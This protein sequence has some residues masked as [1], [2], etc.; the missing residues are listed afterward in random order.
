[1]NQKDPKRY[2]KLKSQIQPYQLKVQ[3]ENEVLKMNSLRNPASESN[4]KH[5]FQELLKNQV[6][7]NTKMRRELSSKVDELYNIKMEMEDMRCKVKNSED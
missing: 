4:E 1:M 6:E 3:K 2:S 7:E 5:E